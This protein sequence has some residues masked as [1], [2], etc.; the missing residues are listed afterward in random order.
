M[1]ATADP[2][3]KAFPDVYRGSAANSFSL[4]LGGPLL[5]N[6]HL[7][8]DA[9]ELLDRQIGASVLLTRVPSLVLSA[10]RTVL[11]LARP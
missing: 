4:V 6:A 5:G 8:R 3:L 11:N 9:L 1:E 2:N 7:E 10:L